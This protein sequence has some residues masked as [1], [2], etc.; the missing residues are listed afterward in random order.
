MTD[1]GTFLFAI[2]AG[3]LFGYCFGHFHR[4]ARRAQHRPQRTPRTPWQ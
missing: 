3:T 4:T 1:L 2:A